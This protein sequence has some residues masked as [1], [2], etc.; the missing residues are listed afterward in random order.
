MPSEYVFFRPFLRSSASRRL[1]GFTLLELL[2][3]IAII[4]ILAAILIPVLTKVR[5][6]ARFSTNLSNVRQWTVACTLHAQDWKGFMPYQGSGS[7]NETSA[8]DVTPFPMIGVLPWWNALPPY[9]GEKTLAERLN[10]GGKL[11]RV[12]ENSVWVSP[13]AELTVA[14]NDW[15]AFLCYA[16]ARS[17]NTPSSSA[18]NRYVANA[19]KIKDPSR[20]VMFAE[21]PHFTRAL[22]NGVPYPFVNAIASPNSTGPFNRNGDDREDGGLRGKAALGFFDGSVRTLTGTQIQ[23]HGTTTDAERGDN[24][25]RIVWRLTPN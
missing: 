24:P 12:G 2:T 14:A 18:A 17:S 1:S 8:N 7:I 5:Q 11:P 22:R 25:D 9:I 13:N 23:A 6:T 15:A 20:T 19:F 4:G 3:V 10:N 21:T 16:P